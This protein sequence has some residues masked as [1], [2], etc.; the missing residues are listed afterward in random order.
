M[1]AC[2]QPDRLALPF[3][4][5]ADDPAAQVVVR[6]GR[7]D[8]LVNNAGTVQGDDL[9]NHDPAAAAEM[10][11]VNALTPLAL[12]AAALPHLA[13]GAAIVNITSINARSPPASALAYAA[14]KAA[15]EN[16]T[17]GCAKALGPRG[18]RVNAV[19]PGAV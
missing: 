17:I 9:D 2:A 16:L 10:M 18:I 7:L 6:F 8:G 5:R 11:Q 4:A 1:F 14:S 13:A 12:I 3:D 15:L 19:S